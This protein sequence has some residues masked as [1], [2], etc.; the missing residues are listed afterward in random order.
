MYRKIGKILK[1]NS[2]GSDTQFPS[3]C[4]E[5]MGPIPCFLNGEF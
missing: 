3:I 2:Q 5:V 4:H 1:E